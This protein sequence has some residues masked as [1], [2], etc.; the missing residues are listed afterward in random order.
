MANNIVTGKTYVPMLDEK[1]VAEAK[2]SILDANEELVRLAENGKDFYVPKMELDGLGQHTRGG[3]Y[4]DG[5]VS[6]TWELHAPDYDRSRMFKVDS[7]D[8]VETAG[9]AYGSLAGAFIKTRVAPEIDAVR[10]AKYAG[11]AGTTATGTLAGGNDTIEALATATITLDEA[12]APTDDRILFITSSVYTPI[13]ILQTIQSREILSRFASVVV[14]PQTRFYSAITLNDGVTSGQ[15]EGGYK[16]G[17]GGV[18]LNFIVIS[19]SAI[20]QSLKH[21]APKVITPEANQM[22]DNWKFGYRVYA[23]NEVFENKVN[24]IYVHKKSA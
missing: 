8:N 2:T 15:E 3:D 5:D 23:V 7:Q 24:G 1:Y 21:V 14:V 17:T 9:V 10:F 4:V 6:L 11:K 13:S 12:E 16:K 22:G 20:I 18:D 19:K